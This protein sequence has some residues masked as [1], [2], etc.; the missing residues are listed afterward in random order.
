MTKKVKLLMGIL[1]VAVT[2]VFITCKPITYYLEQVYK[3]Y[4]KVSEAGTGIPLESVE[5][6]VGAYQ[7][8]VLTNGL[9]DYGLELAEG[10]WVLSYVKDG[11]NT[12]TRTVTVNAKVPRVKVDVVLTRPGFTL[13]GTWASPS[14]IGVPNGVYGYLKLVA[15]VGLPTD[16][17]LYWTRSNAFSGGSASYSISGI[18]A[19]TYTAYAFIDMNANAPNSAA[20]MPDSSDS[21]LQTGQQVNISG[22]QTLNLGSSGWIT[23]GPEASWT[24]VGTWVNPAYNLGGPP[25]KIIS[26]TVSFSIY[27]NTS[28]TTPL[29]I[30]EYDV[31]EDWIFGGAHYFKIHLRTPLPGTP[32]LSFILARVSN[33]NTTL[34]AVVSATTYPASI[35]TTDSSHSIYTRQ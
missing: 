6:F 21:Y 17:A 23:P 1:I 28:A 25:A 22:N 14:G 9:G 27:T 33:D 32:P 35:D 26:T 16:Q 7:Y 24:W 15:G 3:A 20:A 13:S 30:F 31:T 29:G 18:A 2:I 8:S 4:G 10:T 12:E 34:E 19:R 11:Y 5:V